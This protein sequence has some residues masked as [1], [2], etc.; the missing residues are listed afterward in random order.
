MKYTARTKGK[1]TILLATVSKESFVYRRQLMLEFERKNFC[2]IA[3]RTISDS[4][5]SMNFL[6][7]WMTYIRSVER[8]LKGKSKSSG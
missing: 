2:P 7:G 3:K 6:F 1:E 5:N 4:E 8:V